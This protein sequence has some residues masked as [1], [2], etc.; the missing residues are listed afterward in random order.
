MPLLLDDELDEALVDEDVDEEV[1]VEEVV[2]VDEVA[3][4]VPPLEED[5]AG[6]PP[7]LLTDVELLVP[8]APPVRSPNV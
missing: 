7:V 2:L 4:P 3:P 5:V 6:A 8:P 1:L